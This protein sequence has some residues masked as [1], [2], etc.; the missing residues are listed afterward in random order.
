MAFT[1]YY[2]R[3][4]PL[5]MINPV[6]KY[7][8]AG[9]NILVDHRAAA[10][11]SKLQVLDYFFPG[12]FV[13]ECGGDEAVYDYEK[14]YI[15]APRKQ[16][17]LSNW[18]TFKQKI[19]DLEDCLLGN[20]RTEKT[21]KN[22][23]AASSMLRRAVM[24]LCNQEAFFRSIVS[25]LQDIYNRLDALQKEEMNGW[26]KALAAE[27]SSQETREFC[28]VKRT[29]G[30]S[31]EPDIYDELIEKL[32]ASVGERDYRETWVWICIGS[33]FGNYTGRLMK[34]Y[35]VPSVH[36]VKN[37]DSHS[38]RLIP[39]PSLMPKPGF[40][41]RDDVIRKI[42]DLFEDGNRVIFLYGI[43]G[44]GK[45]EIAKKYASVHRNEYDAIIYA[46][47]D[48]SL[49][50]LVISESPFETDP[51]VQ[52]LFKDGSEESDESYFERK[53]DI[54]R[55]IS[56]P[57]TLIIID[58]FNTEMDDDLKKF[59]N[60]RY[61][62][63][64]TTQYD[65]SREYPSIHVKEIEDEESLL[66][67]FMYHYQGYAAERDDPDLI[68]LIH[69]VKNHTYTITLLAH[70]MENSGETPAQMMQAFREKGVLALHET[71]RNREYEKDEASANLIRMF[72][73][74]DFN[75][76]EQKVLKLMSLISSA[77]VPAMVFKQ[78][79]GLS[80][81]RSIL[82]LE[83]RGWLLRS[84]QGISLHPVVCGVLQ[85]VYECRPEE[86]RPFLDAIVH[87][88][89]DAWHFTKKEKELYSRIC[90]HILSQ[91]G[92]L[93]EDTV[94]F[95]RCAAVTAGFAGETELAMRLDR[96]LFA[97]HEKTD[98]LYAYETG[99]A[100]YRIAWVLLF[101]RQEKNAFSEALTWLFKTM[102]IFDHISIE[103]IDQKSTYCGAL[104]NIAKAY[105][106]QYDQ[107]SDP[108]DLEDAL[109]YAEK[110]VHF[111]KMWLKDYCQTKM[112]PAGNLLRL[113]DV[114]IRKREYTKAEQLVDEAYEI[115][116]SIYGE[117]D[118]DVL[119]ASEEKALVLY[120]LGRYEE[121][122]KETEKN[123][124]AY[125]KFYGN[126]NP[127]LVDQMILKIKNCIA[128]NDPDTAFAVKKEALDIALEIYTPDSKKIRILHN[129]H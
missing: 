71:V 49:C 8:D 93:N 6:K 90:R 52:R 72:P 105:T 122:L 82:S 91:I 69:A 45:T 103:T 94:R 65:Y 22:Y 12:L 86:I 21:Y 3:L 56:G 20:S 60:G 46:V 81:T 53:L 41:G 32:N 25:N 36:P 108:K 19:N 80:G 74:F 70:H 110:A 37:V 13:R 28:T 1:L 43:G 15:F 125:Q 30:F 50:R 57:R 7:L 68:N 87:T 99:L 98:G 42:D 61:R 116:T 2:N 75:E 26:M 96:S 102:E 111:S 107:S 124:E 38:Y 39:S 114:L 31:F 76:E 118:P 126:T 97:Y 51:P 9:G 18:G 115:L 119:R 58:N 123:L 83:K 33:L 24:D 59:I 78:W 29:D 17:V 48:S 14:C 67:I 120:E 62:V 85:S 127:S 112:S 55:K 106:E 95:Y 73:I 129:L 113:A 117:N 104:E 47:Y 121:S 40:C 100:S 77:S 128:L 16:G 5:R 11:L 54:I 34:K 64:F 88:L 79:A 23:S 44:I 66:D 4:F 101:S 84:P 109:K 92:E 63:L 35:H 10:Q 27:C 89:K